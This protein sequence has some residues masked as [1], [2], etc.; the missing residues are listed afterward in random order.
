ML[1]M[2]MM[3]F[4]L[5]SNQVQVPVPDAAFGDHGVG[6][7][8]D[9]GGGSLEDYGLEAVIVIKV[10][11]HRG[12]RQVV[13]GM[14]QT[15]QS[16]RQIALMVVVDVGKIGDA[17]TRWRA[18]LTVIRDGTPDQIPNRLRA[19]AVAT[20]RNQ[21]VKLFGQSV[22]QRYGE[23]FHDV[24]LLYPGSAVSQTHPDRFFAVLAATN[25]LT[26]LAAGWSASIQT[27]NQLS[28]GAFHYEASMLP[29][30]LPDQGLRF[31]HAICVSI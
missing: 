5:E 30:P 1:V 19:V 27:G 2:G 6:K 23:A 15:G 28:S 14:L 12:H 18:A 17:M 7:L 8:L 31:W 20:S 29:T 26:S 13:M 21:L 22:I 25:Y 11:V 24:Y 4:D 3:V 16:F 10:A 9:V